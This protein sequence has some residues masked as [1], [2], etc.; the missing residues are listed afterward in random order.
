LVSRHAGITNKYI[1]TL[2]FMADIIDSRPKAIERLGKDA[3]S[4]VKL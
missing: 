3:A 2:L 4:R 1:V